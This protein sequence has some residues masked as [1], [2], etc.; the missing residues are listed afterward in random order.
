MLHRR[1]KRHRIVAWLARLAVGM[2]LFAPLVSRVLVAFSVMPAMTMA[3]DMA[4]PGMVQHQA[5]HASANGNHA[6]HDP[7]PPSTDACGYC[8]LLFHSPALTVTVLVLPQVIPP[9]AVR[10][11]ATALRASALRLPA[12]RSRGPPLA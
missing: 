4:M 6:P 2:M 11:E 9:T 12:R 5:D 3:H 1:A 7:A 8:S 10:W